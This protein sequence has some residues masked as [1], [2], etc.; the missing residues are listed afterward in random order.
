[1][2][3]WSLKQ[4]LSASLWWFYYLQAD[5]QV[6]FLC[7]QLKMAVHRSIRLPGLT[8][9][10][11]C[12]SFTANGCTV[13][14]R[15][16]IWRISQKCLSLSVIKKSIGQIIVIKRNQR[17]E[18]IYPFKFK[19]MYLENKI[20]LGP[21]AQIRYCMMSYVEKRSSM[22]SPKATIQ[23]RF[24]DKKLFWLFILFH[25]RI[26]VKLYLLVSVYFWSCGKDISKVLNGRG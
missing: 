10:L 14:E 12:N 5:L 6:S 7:V 15:T 22:M 21:R 19:F 17:L 20:L 11:I 16:K 3:G 2:N 25:K 4:Q 13:K 24:A 23:L 18:Y 9:S 8:L 26:S 1:M